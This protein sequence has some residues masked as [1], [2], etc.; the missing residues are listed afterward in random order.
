MKVLKFQ[1]GNLEKIVDEIEKII[2]K[3]GIVLSPTDTVYGFLCDYSNKKAIEKLFKLKK[4]E[5]SKPFPIFV[6]NLKMARIFAKINNK[7]I[8]FLKKVWPGKTT[9]IL[10]RKINVFPN[11]FPN[12]KTIGLRVSKHKLIKGLFRKIDYPIVQTSANI[13][14]RPC[15]T[16]IKEILKE[17]VKSSKV[18]PDLIIDAGN[19]KLSKPSQIIDLTKSKPILLRR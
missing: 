9:V 12:K 17:F 18:Q 2:K 5:K 19:L 13:S 14:G 10:E 6:K 11:I 8:C 1:E 4:R 7:E 15:S 16:Q 3:G